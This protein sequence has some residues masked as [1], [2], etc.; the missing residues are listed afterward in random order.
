MTKL[1]NKWI[2]AVYKG[3]DYIC[4]GT[5]D[6]ICNNLNI[7]KSTFHF[8]R[9][10]WYKKNRQTKKNNRIIIVRIDGEDNIW[11]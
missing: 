6:E 10:N 2:Y 3:D 1:S 9:S 8:Y 11:K 7:K 5:I 4:D